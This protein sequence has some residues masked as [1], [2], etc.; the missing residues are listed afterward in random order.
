M[1][2]K[3]LKYPLTKDQQNQRNQLI[4]QLLEHKHVKAFLT[5][6]RVSQ[7]IVEEN[8]YRFKDWVSEKEKAES[9]SKDLLEANPT[10]GE[11]VD[12]VFDHETN[13]LME[14]FVRTDALQSMNESLEY[15]KRYIV[16]DL[17]AQLQ[18]VSF[19]T[20]DIEHES[21]NYLKAI[22]LCEPLELG[23][24]GMYLY[25]DL[26]V[27][28]S[29]LAACITNKFAKQNRSVM[30]VTTSELLT[31]IKTTFGLQ[32]EQEKMFNALKNCDVLV[33]DDLG[34]EPITPWSRD[35]V[36]FPI[37]NSRMENSKLTIFT[38]NYPIQKLESVYSIDS[39]GN[40]DPLR[41]K[42]F[43]DRVSTCATPFEIVGTNRRNHK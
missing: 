16:F 9:V 43:T 39:K 23:K 20:L 19:D 4:A 2:F 1:S 32:F 3:N 10:L 41:A 34:S 22:A 25:G 8:A 6:Y 5:Q 30:F 18:K 33:L 35:E 29:Y 11:Y 28:K 7:K 14:V 37:L 12:L 31:Y 17:P 21:P 38:S 27:G 36:L 13:T 42:R 26:G 24:K 15:L 40:I